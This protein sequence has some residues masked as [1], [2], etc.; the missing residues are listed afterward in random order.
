[1][2]FYLKKMGGNDK[3]RRDVT[4]E[5]F[6]QE[7][8]NS[9]EIFWREFIQNFLDLN[10]VDENKGMSLKITTAPIG[11]STGLR[12]LKDVFS[13]LSGA[14]DKLGYSPQSKLNSA[15]LLIISEINTRG[16]CGNTDLMSAEEN[17]D[18][19]DWISFWFGEGRSTKKG[20]AG[21]RRGQGKATYHSI[22]AYKSLF[23]ITK[24]HDDN[25]KLLFG[26]FRFTETFRLGDSRY[27]H[28]GFFG[29]KETD[30]YDKEVLPVSDEASI[31]QFERNLAIDSRSE[32]GS[33]WVFP[34]VDLA[35][36]QNADIIRV[37]VEEYYF[38]II[39][40]DLTLEINGET[41]N[42]STIRDLMK[43]HGLTE[44]AEQKL[45]FLEEALTSPQFEANRA[46]SA[47][48]PIA[49]D[50]FSE[51]DLGKMRSRL[52][53]GE[54]VGVRL[55]MVVRPINL[56]SRDTFIDVFLQR[57]P[58][59]E[60]T[61]EQ[62]IRSSL[63]IA[64]EKHLRHTPG[65]FLGLTLAKDEAIATFLAQS[66]NAAHLKFNAKYVSDTYHDSLKTIR[67]VRFALPQLARLL[68]HI[69]SRDKDALAS[70]LFIPS[71]D[72]SPA[73]EKNKP[74]APPP[75]LPP[76]MFFGSQRGGKFRLRK[77]SNFA[78]ELP[79][80][81]YLRFGY[82]TGIGGGNPIKKWSHLDFNLSDHAKH[83][84]TATG[85]IVHG[86]KNNE[87]EVEITSEDDFSLILGGVSENIRMAVRVDE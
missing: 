4:G 27:D 5:N 34:F 52:E 63:L 20:S 21:G 82:E 75:D 11:K 86:Q 74:P 17:P 30:S 57:P 42:G 14:C 60:A 48:A 19:G 68:G 35:K 25:R 39:S 70:L 85:A 84:V 15:G 18:D 45:L 44:P 66:E 9:I 40:D 7:S 79:K 38:A 73:K 22:S 29:V 2:K 33:T 61:D 53:R 64:D 62:I 55:P 12:Y 59:L 28:Y 41:L 46:I 65:K 23:A 71:Q 10:R 80:R 87:L 69:S 56:P 51:D 1:M 50:M 54:T 24:R 36:F 32:Y 8:R 37:I 6:K 47:D 81:I 31:S 3:S 58:D 26:Q 83:P 76:P 16:L 78:G 49:D 67:A 72:P 13:D 43:K 77:S